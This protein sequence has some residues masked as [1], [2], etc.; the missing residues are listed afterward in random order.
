MNPQ[1]VLIIGAS[2]HAHSVLSLL[3]RHAGYQPFG[4]IDSFKPSGSQAYGL[5]ILGREADVP[6]L[7]HRH[8]LHHLLVAIGDNA[9]RQAMTERLQLQCKEV[10]FPSLVDPTAVVA[11]DAQLG[12]GVLVMS[13]AHVGSGCVL[14]AGSLLNTQASLDHDGFLGP[15]ASLAPGAITGGHVRIGGRSFIGLGSRV[16]QKVRIG[17]DTVVG[18]GSLV[19]KD[20]PDGIVAYGSPAKAVRTRLPDAPY[21]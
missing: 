9:Q 18:A 10:V 6:Q 1:P 4:L 21:L 12:P 15:Y 13:Q 14:E 19:L 2:G 8:G 16:V 5:P 20:L 7:C 17:S 11:I 3:Y